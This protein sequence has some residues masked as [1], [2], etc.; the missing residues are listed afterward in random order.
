MT[1][2]SLLSFLRGLV[3]MAAL[4]LLVSAVAVEADV[5]ATGITWDRLSRLN[6][7]EARN[8]MHLMSRA[9]N[10]LMGVVFTTVAIAVPLTAN[11]YSLKFLEYFI[12]DRINAL[13]LSAAV[14]AAL[15]LVIV[16]YTIKD[17]YVPRAILGLQI[18]LVVMLFAAI[19][20]YLYYVFRFLHP[21]TLL[22][23]LEAEIRKDLR[24]AR[25]AD[26]EDVPRLRKEVGEGLDHLANIVI[27]S[28]DRL[29]RTTAIEGVLALERSARLYASLKPQIPEGWFHADHQLFLGFSSRAVEEMAE[30]R[31]WTEMKVFGELREIMSAAV[32]RTHDLASVVAKVLRRLGE[33]PSTLHDPVLR[34]LVAE[35][36][37]TFIRLAITRRD[38]RSAF[39]VLDQYRTFAESASAASPDEGLE[40][41][42]YLQYYGQAARDAQLPFLTEVVA[43]ELGGMVTRA[44][45]T[46]SPAKDALLERLLGYDRDNAP[47]LAGVLKAHAIAASRLAQL[48]ETA[49]AAALAGRFA[50]VP[51]HVVQRLRDELLSVTREKYWEVN[52]RRINIYWIPAEQRDALRA[53][54][55]SV[56]LASPA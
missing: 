44:Y 35:Y 6:P 8:L 16:G 3:G 31:T 48:G 56:L 28:V 50:G 37:N 33:E 52:E 34:H 47:L 27:R 30:T 38:Q 9:C 45:E 41:A 25:D 23:R 36:F 7:N 43:H 18:V 20:P 13:M 54:L 4:M 39:L 14:F 21:N 55:D 19:F 24:A 5:F 51:R 12:K 2:S 29:D 49:A 17:D 32:P 42:F 40:I 1:R 46:A 53:F 11:L 15:N 22:D 26:P 10:Q